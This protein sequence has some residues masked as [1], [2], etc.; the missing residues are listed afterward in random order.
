[1]IVD[2]ALITVLA[3]SVVESDAV[4]EFSAHQPAEVTSVLFHDNE[5]GEVEEQ[6]HQYES[7]W[8][9]SLMAKAQKEEEQDSEEEEED[10]EEEDEDDDP[11]E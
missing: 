5:S 9:V 8:R 1:M 6:Q 4:S 3:A 11:P 7:H 2:V 10:A